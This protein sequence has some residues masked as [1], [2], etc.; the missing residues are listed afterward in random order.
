MANTRS[1]GGAETALTRETNES[2]VGL[3]LG[4]GGARGLAHLLMLEAFDE[5]GVRPSVIAGT[6]IGAIFGAAYASGISGLQMRAHMEEILSVRFQT[7][8]EIFGARARRP[9]SLLNLFTAPA[10]LLD[11]EAL[12][13]II[14]PPGTARNFDD[15]K[16]PLKIVASDFYALE[17]KVFTTG[18]LRCAVAASIALPVIFEPVIVEGRAYLDGGLT[19]PLPF[20]L[21]KEEADITVAIDVCGAPVPNSKRHYPTAAEALFASAFIFERTINREKLKSQQPDIYID[22]GTSQFQILDI[23][24]AK[25]ILAAAEPAKERLKAQLQRVLSVE[26]LEQIAPAAPMIALSAPAS[27]PEVKPKRQLLLKKL[28]GRKGKPHA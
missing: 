3:A 23:L 26:T 1:R 16:I 2:R 5:M 9:S 13:D 12:L 14:L 25:E 7:L 6:S 19:N 21:L 10:A 15:L 17:S 11:P 27:G 20:D 24:K 22:A 18:S 8:K 28:K 4:G